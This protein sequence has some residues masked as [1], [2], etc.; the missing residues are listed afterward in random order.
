[1][2]NHRRILNATGAAAIA[3]TLASAQ[4]FR[5]RE[6]RLHL[7][8]VGGA[9]GDVNFTATVDS[10]NGAAYDLQFLTT[11]MTAAADY[12]WTGD[13]Q[14]EPGDEIDFAYANGG[15]KTYGLTIV[16]DLL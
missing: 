12:I 16:Y 11:D 6:V 4:S 2:M 8:A 14:F 15:T 5:L 13:L 1:M 7:S 3:T 9:V 10:I